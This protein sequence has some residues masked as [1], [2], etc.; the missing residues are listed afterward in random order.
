MRS[1]GPI[2]RPERSFLRTALGLTFMP[3]HDTRSGRRKRYLA[4]KPLS[5]A[6]RQ[7]GLPLV[8]TLTTVVFYVV[9][10]SAVLGDRILPGSLFLGLSASMSPLARLASCTSYIGGSG[11][12]SRRLRTDK[13]PPHANT[14]THGGLSHDARP[15]PDARCDAFIGKL[16]RLGRY[17]R[18]V[19][20]MAVSVRRHLGRTGHCTTCLR[21]LVVG[22]VADWVATTGSVRFCY[23]AS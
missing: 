2:A 19:C 21:C 22:V 1:F 11:Y 20:G 12:Q 14:G 5:C 16:H 6:A 13:P 7:A 23:R 4:K 8:V 9:G 10:Q 17:V 3:I 15:H 18:L